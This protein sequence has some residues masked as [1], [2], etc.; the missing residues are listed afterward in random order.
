MIDKVN[1]YINI[2]IIYAILGF[3]V[4]TFMKHV[5]F[6]KMQNGSLYGPWI[7]IYGIG[8]VLLIIT[9]RLTDK[10][11]IK[12]ITKNIL[13]FLFSSI[14]LSLLEFIG[15]IYLENT[16]GKIFWR[17][18]ALKFNIGHY[19]SIEIALL[20]G[21]MSLVIKYILYPITDKLS[22][23]IPSIITYLVFISFLIDLLISHINNKF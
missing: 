14:T 11:K 9:I 20:W 16:T 17:Y 12:N 1:Y 21:V 2:F 7:P 8:C 3:G 5:F 6:P 10:L 13:L 23:K 19:V 18:D 22:K 15:G 4:E